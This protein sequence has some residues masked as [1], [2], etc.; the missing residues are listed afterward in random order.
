MIP[1]KC[2]SVLAALLIVGVAFAAMGSDPGTVGT[3]YSDPIEVDYDLST[4][5][6]VELPGS[7]TMF[8][9][10]VVA[11][12]L[13]DDSDPKNPIYSGYE[14]KN[15]QNFV[16]TDL[17]PGTYHL[18]IIFQYDRGDGVQAYGQE[19]IINIHAG[20][21]HTHTVTYD[22]NGGSE[23]PD[24]V[25]TDYSDASPVTLA[26]SPVLSDRPFLGWLVDGTLYRPGDTVSVPA[27]GS[28]TATAQWGEKSVTQKFT[29]L[30]G[31]TVYA[32]IGTSVDITYAGTANTAMRLVLDDSTCGLVC[33]DYE[34]QNDTDRNVSGIFLKEGTFAVNAVHQNVPYGTITFVVSKSYG[35][36][37][38]HVVSYDSDG[39]S[40]QSP[41]VV[42]DSYSGTSSVQLTTE[43]TKSGSVLT[44]WKI[45]NTV[46]S[47]GTAYSVSANKV[48]AATAEWTQDEI[49]L[50]TPETQ[51]AVSGSTVSFTA[52]YSTNGGDPDVTYSV[53]DVPTGF[54]VTVDGSEIIIKCPFVGETTDYT[55]TLIASATDYESTQCTVTV[56]VVP[57]LQFN[58][59]PSAGI[60]G[61]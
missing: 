14:I 59:D 61:A 17:E 8:V 54:T 32:V 41:S 31:E 7:G 15:F 40:S 60:L 42:W 11:I 21:P 55:F 9:L 10:N 19:Y 29:E 5:D 26:S 28:V 23:L 1:V 4:Q 52:D 25:V 18:Y 33:T 27:D 24:T 51:Y 38:A 39:G 56:T 34:T 44:G 2:A 49:H 36:T 6:Y 12:S 3:N 57:V 58:N 13:Y 20:D 37:Y 43:P 46:Y 16:A 35:S 22:S 48:V 45:G 50:D 30:N 53:S 47:P